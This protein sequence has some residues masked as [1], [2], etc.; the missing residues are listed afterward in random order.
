MAGEHTK[1]LQLAP[2]P[3]PT[4]RKLIAGHRGLTQAYEL[5]D[6]SADRALALRDEPLQEGETRASR[7]QAIC[8]LVRAWSEATQTIRI[9]RGKPLPGSLRPIAKPK[10]QKHISLAPSEE[11]SSPADKP[12]S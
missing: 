11:P 10:K 12:A 1:H 5:R 3:D 7:A 2:N 9:L 8:A 4:R 6:L